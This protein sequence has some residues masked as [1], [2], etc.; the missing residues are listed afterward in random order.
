MRELVELLAV[1]DAA[2]QGGGGGAAHQVHAAGCQGG[3][4]SRH[5]QRSASC[6]VLRSL[7]ATPASTAAV[8]VAVISDPH[9]SI[10][11][12]IFFIFYST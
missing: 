4:T 8:D 1:S 3:I 5:L 9:K 11:Q 12:M 10:D 7:E 2:V 6:R